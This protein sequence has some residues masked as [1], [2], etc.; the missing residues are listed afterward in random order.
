MNNFK[1]KIKIAIAYDTYRTFKAKNGECYT[2]IPLASKN[3]FKEALETLKKEQDSIRG[4]NK[5]MVDFLK[6]ILK[7]PKIKSSDEKFIFE[8]FSSR[9][10]FQVKNQV[11]LKEFSSYISILINVFPETTFQENYF[12]EI[13]CDLLNFFEGNYQDIDILPPIFFV[14][15]EYFEHHE[16]EEPLSRFFNLF[17][18]ELDKSSSEAIFEAIYTHILAKTNG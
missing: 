3:A 11:F 8:D 13:L 7:K 4:Q 12:K 2:H 17:S 5:L 14:F 15:V 16:Y 1:R 6:E 9:R 10:G 18:S